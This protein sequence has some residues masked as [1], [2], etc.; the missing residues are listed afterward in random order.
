MPICPVDQGKW[1]KLLCFVITPFNLL[2]G[3]SRTLGVHQELSTSLL[4]D[5]RPLRAPVSVSPNG[6]KL[7]RYSV[8]STHRH[9][10]R[11]KR[12]VRAVRCCVVRRKSNHFVRPSGQQSVCGRRGGALNGS[13]WLLEARTLEQAV[14][15]V[16][17]HCREFSQDD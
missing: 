5:D 11:L 10:L 7:L 8:S 16:H 3:R 12:Q 15:V 6:R 9:I 17:T 2:A 14:G 4:R 13:R 1:N